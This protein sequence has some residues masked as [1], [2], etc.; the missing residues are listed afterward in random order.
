MPEALL[1]LGFQSNVSTMCVCVAV[2]LAASRFAVGAG[3]SRSR[4]QRRTFK[5]T[6]QS[7]K[8]DLAPANEPQD[9][10]V[11]SRQRSVDAPFLDRVRSRACDSSTCN[12][13]H[14]SHG[15]TTCMDVVCMYVCMY[16]LV[17]SRESKR[18]EPSKSKGPSFCPKQ[19]ATAGNSSCCLFLVFL[20]WRFAFF[21]GGSR[22]TIKITVTHRYIFPSLTNSSPSLSRKTHGRTNSHLLGFCALMTYY[23]TYLQVRD[24]LLAHY[25]LLFTRSGTYMEHSFHSPAAARVL[26]RLAVGGGSFTRTFHIHE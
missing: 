12:I 22:S 20:V 25:S 10:R 6:V 4:A 23:L 19:P 1:F 14:T 26:L 21:V 15:H 5:N 8:L 18:K 16:V 13:H 3:S 11:E 24:Y 7:M 17:R 2:V 9:R